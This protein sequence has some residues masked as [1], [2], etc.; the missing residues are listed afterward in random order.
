MWGGGAGGDW[1]PSPFTHQNKNDLRGKLVSLFP[2]RNWVRYSSR[3]EGLFSTPAVSWA[4]QLGGEL[5]PAPWAQSSRILQAAFDDSWQLEGGGKFGEKN[6]TGGGG[7]R[8]PHF[9]WCNQLPSESE[10]PASQLTIREH[11]FSARCSRVEKLNYLRGPLSSHR[12]LRRNG[13]EVMGMMGLLH[14][15]LK[16]QLGIISSLAQHLPC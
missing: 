10:L 11:S 13:E 14:W 3:E 9:Y 8:H 2:S 16:V 7:E 15:S 5:Q 4:T 1:C 6:R 12:K